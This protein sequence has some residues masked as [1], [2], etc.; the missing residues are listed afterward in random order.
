MENNQLF[1]QKSLER[2]SSPEELHD[3]MRVTSP[4]LW[5]IL[6]AIIVLLVGFIIYASTARLENTITLQVAL[7]NI[8]VDEANTEY[9]PGAKISLISA[10]LP[11][12]YADTVK[13][14]MEVRF[15]GEKGKVS[16]VLSGDQNQEI[17]LIIETEREYIPKPDGL[18]DAELVLESATPIS[19][20]WN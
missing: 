14:G 1:R 19:F 5:M 12:E 11:A 8:E 4:R 20:L 9:P 16:M 2:I 3:Y 6:G 18:Y 15:D 10:V 7:Q 17:N 13:P